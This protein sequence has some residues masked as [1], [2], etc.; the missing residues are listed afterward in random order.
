MNTSKFKKLAKVLEVV[1]FLVSV[2]NL[3]SMF[4]LT[5]MYFFKENRNF[6]I[7]PPNNGWS[8]FSAMKNMPNPSKQLLAGI[9]V[10]VPV[11]T[12]YSIIFF[13]SSRFFKRLSQNQTPFSEGNKKLLKRIGIALI[14]LGV[15][16]SLIYS[17]IVSVLTIDGYYINFN[18]G[19]SFLVGLVVYCMAEVI[20]YGL[21]L[22]NF[23]ED[24][25]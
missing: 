15:T 21:E 14:C 22:Q 5:F 23:S 10:A 3:L 9:I 13:Q 1:L 2:F 18:I 8:I 4:L 20:N 25:V 11:L 17:L 12:I 7:S 6:L 19:V 16:P 24:V